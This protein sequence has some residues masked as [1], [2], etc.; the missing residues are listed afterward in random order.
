MPPGS[1]AGVGGMVGG[2]PTPKLCSRR[3]TVFLHVPFRGRVKI[4]LPQLN[5]FDPEKFR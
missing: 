4:G 3:Q 1:H 5:L 2:V